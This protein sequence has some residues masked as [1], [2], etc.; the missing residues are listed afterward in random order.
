MDFLNYILLAVTVVTTLGGL[1]AVFFT[2]A[3]KST[4]E[5]LRENNLALSEANKRL[6]AENAAYK[7][8]ITSL[9]QRVLTLES[10]KTPSLD[11]LTTLTVKNHAQLEKS[12]TKLI[13]AVQKVAEIKS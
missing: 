6:E 7:V 3:G 11:A 8:T 9:E 1:S 10:L 4:R 12:I 13:K 5:L 2:V